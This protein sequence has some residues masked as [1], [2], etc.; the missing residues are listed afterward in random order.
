MARLLSQHPELRPTGSA[1]YRLGLV[2]Q[3]GPSRVL[4]SPL[5]PENVGFS[6]WARKWWDRLER[7]SLGS[8]PALH[9]IPRSKEHHPA[10]SGPQFPQ[11]PTSQ[12]RKG[13]IS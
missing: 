8:S 6:P 4:S 5:A 13:G 12:E 9:L 3:R 1:P 2:L 11:T 10:L 7:T